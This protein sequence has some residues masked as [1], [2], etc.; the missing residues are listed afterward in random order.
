MYVAPPMPESSLAPAERERNHLA[1]RI[2]RVGGLASAVD[3]G[4]ADDVAA[5]GSWFAYR[6]FPRLDLAKF[7]VGAALAESAPP[8]TLLLVP[9]PEQPPTAT[10]LLLLGGASERSG[11]DFG[12]A[13]EG[14]DA[15][16]GNWMPT[17]DRSMI[18]PWK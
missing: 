15:S 1:T 6:K 5:T 12:G 7:K 4:F 2:Q 3:V 16:R 13:M 8:P 14:G 9:P 18:V 11:G 17:Q 10:D